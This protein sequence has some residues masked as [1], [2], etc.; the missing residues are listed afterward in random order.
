MVCKF[1][2]IRTVVFLALISCVFSSCE[3]K[4]EKKVNKVN[5]LLPNGELLTVEK[6]NIKTTSIGI[7]S[8]R[9]YGTK[10]NYSYNVRINKHDINWDGG[11]GKPEPKNIIFCKD[12]IYIRY[13]KN[14]TIKIEKPNST[15]STDSITKYNYHTKVIEVFQ[16]NVDERYFF[17][18]FGDNYW[19]NITP[20]NY[21]VLKNS[22]EEY[23]IPNDN[24]ILLYEKIIAN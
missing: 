5:E 14:K 22:C 7:I 1:N 20:E 3:Q 23:T 24:E 4:T 18:W 13:L 19:L 6:T 21:T 16:K 17:N 11:S 2:I 15:D 9:S 10:H 12:T 8:K